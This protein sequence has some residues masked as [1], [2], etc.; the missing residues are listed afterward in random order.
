MTEKIH[1]ILVYCFTF[2]ICSIISYLIYPFYNLLSIYIVVV[3]IVFLCSVFSTDKMKFKKYAIILLILFFVG[4]IM[5]LGA[6]LVWSIYVL[7]EYDFSYLRSSHGHEY[8][9]MMLITTVAIF[10]FTSFYTCYHNVCH[11]DQREKKENKNLSIK[12]GYS[13]RSNSLKK[14][15]KIENLLDNDVKSNCDHDEVL[16]DSNASL[17]SSKFKTTSV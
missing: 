6:A 12:R 5:G 14:S 9:L 4:H 11:V 7:M 2:F 8:P 3:L 1:K 17:L 13:L 10:C 16:F 15:C